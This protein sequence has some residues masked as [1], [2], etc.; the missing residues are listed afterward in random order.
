[1]WNAL[2]NEI[3][4]SVTCVVTLALDPYHPVVGP[5][6]RTR[7]LLIG[8]SRAP[9]LEQLDERAGPDGFWAVGGAVRSEEP[10]ENLQIT[11]VEGGLAATVRPEGR[12][13]VGNLKPGEYTLEVSCEGREPSQHKIAVP[14]ENYDLEIV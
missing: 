3:R 7:E 8:P 5:V 6:V 4:P 12:F 2:D 11:L 13:V 9:P 1:M 10:L 14:S